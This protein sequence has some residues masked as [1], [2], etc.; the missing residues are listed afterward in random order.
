MIKVIVFIPV[1]DNDGLPFA[2]ADFAR[3]EAELRG[4]SGGFTRRAGVSGEWRDGDRVY[5]DESIEYVVTLEPWRALAGWLST[6]DAARA[7][8]RQEALYIEVNGYPEILGP[9]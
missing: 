5:E 6:I 2:R 8:F 9:L 4:L 7:A 1:R 3:F